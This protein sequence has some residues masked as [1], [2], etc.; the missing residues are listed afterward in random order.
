M[1]ELTFRMAYPIIEGG[2]RVTDN[3]YSRLYELLVQ[4]HQLL[5]GEN[6]HFSC[7]LQQLSA[8]ILFLLLLVIEDTVDE[9]VL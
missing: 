7:L 5:F 2:Q 1:D 3:R 6:A 8:L 4:I 9:E